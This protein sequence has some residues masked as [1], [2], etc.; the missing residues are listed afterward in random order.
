MK[1]GSIRNRDVWPATPEYRCKAVMS[2]NQE[3]MDKVNLHSFVRSIYV[4]ECRDF[5]LLGE[6][7]EENGPPSGE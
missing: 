6:G 3:V 7:F 2:F 1:S 5:V 4:Q